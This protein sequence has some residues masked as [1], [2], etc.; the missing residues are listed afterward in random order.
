M[1]DNT[2]SEELRLA[3]E[4]RALRLAELGPEP[5]WWRPF[6]R[7]RWRRA[8]RGICA[9]TLDETSLLLRRIYSR[10][11]SERMAVRAVAPFDLANLR[12]DRG[13]FNGDAFAFPPKK[14]DGDHEQ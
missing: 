2:I 1:S 6:A 14:G 5:P 7:R 11:Y 9:V 12:R 13:S 10:V 4:E 3:R 8:R